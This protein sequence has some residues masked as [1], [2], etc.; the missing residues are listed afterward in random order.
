[1][2]LRKPGVA[3]HEVRFREL[4]LETYLEVLRFVKR[5]VH[6]SWAE[7]VTAE[8]FLTA[9]RRFE[10]LPRRP[11]EARAWLYGVARNSL[12]NDHRAQGRREALAVRLKE[13]PDLSA[14]A[15][16]DI[17]A[18][19]ADLARAWHRLS[20]T[21]QET[22][23]LRVFDQLTSPQAALVLGITPVNYRLRLLRAR[24]S[25]RREMEPTRC[26]D[27]PTEAYR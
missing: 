10:D 5:R 11:E 12:L 18:L 14:G 19:R 13:V 22:L 1:M 25:L 17:A 2:N 8:V 9:W 26:T 7:D 21:E 20:P 6:S 27:T 4:Y 3:L 16:D 23:S 24:R 15:P